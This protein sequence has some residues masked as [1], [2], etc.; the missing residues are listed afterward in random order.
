[1]VQLPNFKVTTA[2]STN[3]SIIRCIRWV[4]LSC[5]TIDASS[6]LWNLNTS[7]PIKRLISL[8]TI[9]DIDYLLSIFFSITGGRLVVQI[10]WTPRPSE[11]NSPFLPA[12]KL[13]INKMHISEKKTKI[14]TFWIFTSK[15]KETT[16]FER[17][18]RKSM[19]TSSNDSTTLRNCRQIHG[20]FRSGWSPPNFELYHSEASLQKID[21]KQSIFLR[22]MNKCDG[23]HNRVVP[24]SN[25]QLWTEID[26]IDRSWMADRHLFLVMKPVRQPAYSNMIAISKD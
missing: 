24:I 25:V 20:V 1:M 10:E 2:T 17:S 11:P 15:R 8:R 23:H 9:R 6:P 18:Y 7:Y 5:D 16:L 13:K 22:H 14:K 19:R 12:A 4:V 3:S 21:R 26:K